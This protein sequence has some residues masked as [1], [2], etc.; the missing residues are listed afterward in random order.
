SPPWDDGMP[1]LPQT[2]GRRWQ[3]WLCSPPL[4]TGSAYITSSKC[5]L[6]AVILVTKKG[7]EVCANPKESWVQN[8]LELFQNEEN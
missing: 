7:K 3:G 5:R 4:H 2:A 8:Y 6:P 1:S